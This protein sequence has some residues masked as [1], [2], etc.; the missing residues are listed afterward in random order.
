MLHTIALSLAATPLALPNDASVQVLLREGD[1]LSN[2]AVVS[3]FRDLTLADDGSWAAIV[4]D[5]LNRYVVVDGALSRS[6]GDPVL[7][8]QISEFLEV[9]MARDGTVGGL[10]EVLLT[11]GDV[12]RRVQIGVDVVLQEGQ[13]LNTGPVGISGEVTTIRG[14]DFEG[15]EMSVRCQI[16]PPGG[17]P[18]PCFLV[19]SIG[20]GSFTATGGYVS[21]DAVPGLADTFH[22]VFEDLD[23]GAGSRSSATAL[24]DAPLSG[25]FGVVVDGVG[26]A[27][28]GG[29][30]PAPGSTWTFESRPRVRVNHADGHA[31]SGTLELSSGSSV[32]V[33]YSFDSGGSQALVVE[34]G[35]PNGVLVG[36][37][38]PFDRLPMELADDGTVAYVYA[39]TTGAERLMVGLDEAIVTGQTTTDGSL[40]TGLLASTLGDRI[41]LSS[42]GVE[43]LVL[44]QLDGGDLGLLRAERGIETPT[45]CPAVPNS[46][47]QTGRLAA[48]GSRY[49]ANDDLTI[50]ATRLPAGQFA[51]LVGA[52]A[53]GFTANP[54]GSD[55]NL[56]LGGGIGRF[57]ALVAAADGIGRVSFPLD[58]SALPQPSF[59][60]PAAP[61]DTWY[62]QAWHRD[63]TP[64]APQSNFTEAI[65][66]TFR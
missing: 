58:L 57:N 35:T 54:G 29:A 61:G 6:E 21:G 20:G 33:L 66:V 28:S 56:C 16:T 3:T 44:A 22:S 31:I 14:F 60:V 64:S 25:L 45:T 42:D 12:E 50:D 4:G 18:T 36:P 9:E 48:S 41:A 32:G 10:Y 5:G 49:V 65:G 11:G 8:G 51:L 47:G 55:G 53:E 59:T 15:L 24:L 37:A 39:S 63:G 46:T 34:G 30:G 62:F 38:A 52:L 19:G 1:T 43:A 23:Y 27:E 26:V 13:T 7:G 2:G 40:V 17:S